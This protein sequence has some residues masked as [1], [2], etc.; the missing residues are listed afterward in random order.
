MLLKP[1]AEN[2]LTM[3]PTDGKGKEFKKQLIYPI[4]NALENLEEMERSGVNPGNHVMYLK[5]DHHGLDYA[6]GKY[7]LIFDL[8]REGNVILYKTKNASIEDIGSD[9]IHIT[10]HEDVEKICS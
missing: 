9:T 2:L 10:F 5:L 3:K 4:G 1:M 6:S 7:D 8:F